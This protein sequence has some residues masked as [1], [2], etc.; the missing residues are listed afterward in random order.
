MSVYLI[1]GYNLLHE[2]LG[3]RESGVSGGERARG[4]RLRGSRGRMADRVR[5]T[6]GRATESRG[7]DD[8]RGP[9]GAGA[10]GLPSRATVDLEDER[11]RLIDRIASYMGGTSDRA[12][13]VFDSHSQMLQKSESATA[14]VEVYF[15]S[16]SHSADAIIERE[17]YAVS[18]GESVVVVSS[19]HQLQQTIF[20]PNVI[21]CSSRQFALELQE[22]TKRIANPQNCI[23]MSH[24]IEERIPAGTLEKLARLRDQL[25]HETSP[26]GPQ[27]SK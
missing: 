20:L 26:E 17:V 25:E 7:R 14:Q 11:R 5:A 16:F 22:H 27:R 15:G 23:T 13:V 3:Q 19:D 12:V 1:D 9:E 10:A 8:A 18:A 6:T 24:R 4:A 2:I 21:R